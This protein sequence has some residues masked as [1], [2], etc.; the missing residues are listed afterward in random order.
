[1]GVIYLRTNLVN[2]MQY[3]GQ[4]K[5][6][7][8]REG[9]W[10]CF[11]LRYA[12]Q[13][14]TDDRKK[15]G[16]ENWSVKIL[17]ECENDKLDELEK[18]WI[19]KLDTMYP[20][21]YNC[22]RGGAI[23]FKHSDETKHK[24]SEANSGEKNGQ[25]GKDPW[26]KGIKGCFSDETLKKMSESNMGNTSALGHTVSEKVKKAISVKKKGVSNVKL[27]KPL[28][29]FDRTTGETVKNWSS[30]AEAKKNG[31][32]HAD[33]VARGERPHCCNY[34]FRYLKKED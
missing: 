16:L 25:Y 4:T 9:H 24:I 8:V 12:N 34:G 3:V 6:F 17:E 23:T 14:M 26:N 10:K 22:T 11:K 19:E 21:G 18:F 27:T 15:Y 28:E 33:A 1:M 32:L 7:K 29:Q 20:N 2:G 31:F 13:L 5:N 30:V